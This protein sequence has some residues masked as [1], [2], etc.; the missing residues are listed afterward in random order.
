M[1]GKIKFSQ[2][3]KS[4]DQKNERSKL[5]KGLY[6]ASFQIIEHTTRL[7]P[8]MM[9]ALVV[10][11]LH[12]MFVISVNDAPYLSHIGLFN[13]ILKWISF[14]NVDILM[15]QKNEPV[16]SLLIVIVALLLNLIALFC[17]YLLRKQE[18]EKFEWAKK[19]GSF[20]FLIIFPAFNI[21]F[22]IVFGSQLNCYSAIYNDECWTGI[23]I[24]KFLFSLI[25]LFLQ[26]FILALTIGALY[27][28]NVVLKF[29]FNGSAKLLMI[30]IELEK[31]ILAAA[32]IIDTHKVYQIQTL[33]VLSVL[34]LVK[35]F[36]GLK[37]QIFYRLSLNRLLIFLE[38]CYTLRTIISLSLR[39][40]ESTAENWTFVVTTYGIVILGSLAFTNFASMDI[41][42]KFTIATS[43]K[44]EE[45]IIEFLN[46]LIISFRQHNTNLKMRQ[47]IINYFAF[48]TEKCS[49]LELCP[50]KSVLNLLLDFSEANDQE[51]RVAFFSFVVHLIRE[52]QIRFPKTQALFMVRLFIELSELGC[53]NSV[54][55]KMRLLLT[56]KLDM[57]A[58]F[59]IFVLELSY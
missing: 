3:T 57:N 39:Y 26:L 31:I 10:S 9:I 50:C 33:V 1:E 56:N 34:F 24:T 14:T 23:H 16:L 52:Y 38:T 48:H 20:F 32:Y 42:R 40:S 11:W 2:L 19:L 35:V 5:I 47:K 22:Y 28:N 7:L 55:F 49:N 17:F 46:I 41:I 12:K 29:P 37:A 36:F 45:S 15:R 54:V 25:G 8:F 51:C 18:Y 44:S 53:V 30:I 13:G 4:S 58:L 43:F 6:T 59:N 21:S 27:I